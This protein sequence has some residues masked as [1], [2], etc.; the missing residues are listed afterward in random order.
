MARPSVDDSLLLMR[1]RFGLPERGPLLDDMHSQAHR[2]SDLNLHPVRRPSRSVDE[3]QMWLPSQL[4][5]P[6]PEP[7]LR[8]STPLKEEQVNRS[9]QLASP[10]SRPRRLP[11]FEEEKARWL[12]ELYQ[13]KPK[14]RAAS[15]P[16]LLATSVS[17]PQL[18][19]HGSTEAAVGF[20]G[21]EGGVTQAAD[22]NSFSHGSEVLPLDSTDLS[23]KHRAPQHQ[24]ASAASLRRRH[25]SG[26]RGILLPSLQPVRQLT[27]RDALQGSTGASTSTN[28][29]STSVASELNVTAGDDNSDKVARFRVEVDNGR[30]THFAILQDQHSEGEDEEEQEIDLGDGHDAIRTVA[31]Q[32]FNSRQTIRSTSAR[33]LLCAL[34]QPRNL[35]FTPLGSGY[36]NA[37]GEVFR[38][39]LWLEESYDPFGSLP[40]PRPRQWR[41]RK[42]WQLD[43]SIWSARKHH[44]NSRSYYE[45]AESLHSIFDTD[46]QI[47]KVNVAKALR[48]ADENGRDWSDADGNGTHDAIDEVGSALW[49]HY[50]M[51]MGAF[52]YYCI[53]FD[54]GKDVHGEI[55]AFAMSYNAFTEFARDCSLIGAACPLKALDLVW[56]TVNALRPDALIAKLDRFNHKRTM[57]T[58]EFLEALVRL[59]ITLYCQPGMQHK[60]SHAVSCLLTRL[61]SALP[62]EAFQNSNTFRKL[63]CYIELTDT[64]LRRHASSLRALFSVYAGVNR[65]RSDDLQHRQFMSI[66]EWLSMLEHM[67]LVWCGQISVFAAKQIFKWSM[68]RARPDHTIES[69]RKMRQLAFEDWLEAL[70][71]LAC[72]MALPTDAELDAA[73]AQDAGEFLHGLQ[74]DG[75]G[76]DRFVREHRAD[77]RGQPRQHVSRCVAH[78]IALLLR[79][80]KQDVAKSIVD[81]MGSK[82]GSRSSRTEVSENEVIEFE[83]RRRSG[84]VLSHAQA[85]S[86]LLEGIRSSESIVRGR[87]LAS[88]RAVEIFS[89]LSDEQ[90]FTLCEAMSQ[91]QYTAGEYVFEQG[92]DG[93]TFYIV[94]EGTAAVLRAEP[95]NPDVERELAMLSEGSFFG[96]R[97]LLKNQVRYAG[98]R[99]ESPRLLTMCINRAAFEQALGSPLE[100]LMPD[101]YSLD[102]T[103]LIQRLASV[104]L[105][106][107]LSPARVK[108]VADRCTEV[109]FAKGTDVVRQGEEGDVLFVITRGTADVLRWPEADSH[110]EPNE[111]MVEADY[112]VHQPATPTLLA[113]LVAWQSFGERALLKNDTRFAS[114]R[115]TSAELQAMSISRAVAEAALGVTNLAELNDVD[116]V[117]DSHHAATLPA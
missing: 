84:R 2:Q 71:R 10:D 24:R 107:T 9:P 95:G 111:R 1:K 62:P 45:T 115:V 11:A 44:G 59:A 4:A 78:L 102:E 13:I 75:N 25:S 41:R 32:G 12:G 8:P 81:E 103:E 89:S 42:K 114:V 21:L 105:F 27:M 17:L 76:L 35:T 74:D 3:I 117:Y 106:S 85:S 67:G 60:V 53:L 49:H 47:T 34:D 40:P 110:E 28:G 90:L 68:I 6:L 26:S 58:H 112:G 36:H 52:D 38:N 113:Q 14:S 5:P 116:K 61:R 37:I 86:A 7:E 108:V 97:A 31:L 96:E 92:E 29:T 15:Q 109:T 66:G 51:I 69:E 46:W 77:W 22:S 70:V 63:R 55:D 19:I 48:R 54:T 56:T 79:S 73:G 87:Q 16:Q 101:R 94:I 65:N 57:C 50:S 18:D 82:D 23:R 33:N 93:D 99:T 20:Q 100:A 39:R 91:A 83:K 98:V 104:P 72:T 43:G 80:V 30:S 64:S 88:L